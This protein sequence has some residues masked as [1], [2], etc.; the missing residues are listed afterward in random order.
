MSIL[1]KTFILLLGVSAKYCID[2]LELFPHCGVIQEVNQKFEALHF[3]I[4]VAVG[5]SAN[6]HVLQ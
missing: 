4:G 3:V 1:N 2:Y 5:E 6:F